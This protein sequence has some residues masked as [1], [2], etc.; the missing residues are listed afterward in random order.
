MDDALLTIVYRLSSL[1]HRHGPENSNTHPAAPAHAHTLTSTIARSDATWQVVERIEK[2]ADAMR[3]RLARIVLMLLVFGLVAC[4]GS[5]TSGASVSC[6]GS[7]KASTGLGIGEGLELLGSLS[8]QV[9]TSGALRGRFAGGGRSPIQV[10]GQVSG[11]S[12]NLAA[13]LGGGQY[14]FGS[15]TAQSSANGCPTI[16]GGPLAIEAAPGSNSAEQVGSW[17]YSAK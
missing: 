1:V 11:R 13:D 12:V 15:G 16:A 4:G 10:V 3:G 2:E 7:F 17:F 14:L 8:F 9:D 5:A 6:S